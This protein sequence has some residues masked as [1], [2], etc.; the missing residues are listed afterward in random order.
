VGSF[1]E[2]VRDLRRFDGRREVVKQLR[3]EIRKPLPTVRRAIKA[4][5]LATLPSGGGLN[6]WVAQTRVSAVVRVAGRGARV[7]MKGT[8]ASVKGKA[9]TRQVD[10]GSTRHPTWGR[11]SQGSWHVQ[12]VPAGYFTEPASEATQWRDAALAA[13]DGALATLR[14]G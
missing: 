8:R 3:K 5:A 11:R 9:S 6:V 2:L 10:S 4:R 13:V 12:A 14:G 7:G 1:D